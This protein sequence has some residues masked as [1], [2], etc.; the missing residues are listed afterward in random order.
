MAVDVELYQEEHPDG[1]GLRDAV[2]EEEG[3]YEVGS[4]EELEGG[5]SP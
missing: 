4:G 3:G 5:R 2:E 1:D